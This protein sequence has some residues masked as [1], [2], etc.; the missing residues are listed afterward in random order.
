MQ[1]GAASRDC[2]NRWLL[3]WLGATSERRG[4]CKLVPYFVEHR[5]GAYQVG[6]VKALGE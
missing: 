3:H 5:L 1:G 6:G 2:L 4:G